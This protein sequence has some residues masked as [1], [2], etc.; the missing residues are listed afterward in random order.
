[1]LI[2][3]VLTNCVL[4]IE[5]VYLQLDNFDLICLCALKRF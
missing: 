1:M 2:N 5:Y 4:D 3:I